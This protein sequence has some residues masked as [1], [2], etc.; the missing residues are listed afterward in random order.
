MY[1]HDGEA[2]IVKR[3]FYE[4]RFKRPPNIELLRQWFH[5][6]VVI[7]NQGKLYFCDRID[8]VEFEEIV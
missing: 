2:Y 4:G 5:C 1:G 7:R 6:D 8:S 3:E